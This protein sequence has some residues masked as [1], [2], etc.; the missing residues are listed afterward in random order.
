MLTSESSSYVGFNLLS[1]VVMNMHCTEKYSKSQ[2]FVQKF[3]FDKKHNIF[4]SFSP[5][6]F[7][8]IFL[9][10]SKLSTAKKSK[11]TTFS[12]VFHPQK[13]RQFFTGNQSWIFGQKMK[14][15]NSVLKI[16]IFEVETT[17][18]SCLMEF[19]TMKMFAKMW[20][21]RW[22]ILQWFY[23]CLEEFEF[24]RQKLK[25]VRRRIFEFFVAKNKH[26][27]KIIWIFAPKITYVYQIQK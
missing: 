13:N 17:K 15:S 24:S 18:F 7:L 4:T 5:K 14:I 16:G 20:V 26:K 22:R 27:K 25:T 11:T 10:N 12:R 1:A 6:I 21:G 23:M 2:I 9:V 8:T 3:N 19:S